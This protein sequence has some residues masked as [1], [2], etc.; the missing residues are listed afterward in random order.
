MNHNQ[1][2]NIAG[3]VWGLVG[4]MLVLRG[5]D[6]FKLAVEQQQ[7][8]QT[9]LM[10]AIAISLV[11]GGV[12]GKLVFSKTAR[13][14]KARISALPT[15]LKVHQVYSPRF[16]L[17]ITAMMAF[18]FSLRSFNE[19]IGGYVVVAAI[20]VGVGLALTVSSFYYWKPESGTTAKTES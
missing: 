20:Y 12:K 9:A 10:A 16:Y 3:G 8:S 4:V 11:I 17:F 15:P 13:K 19:L 7:A 18:G 14:N 2:F 1:L 6:M 5:A